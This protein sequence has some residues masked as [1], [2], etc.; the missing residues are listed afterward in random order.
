MPE[1]D[2]SKATL[3]KYLSLINDKAQ[4][5]QLALSIELE[6]EHLRLLVGADT[7]GR[8]IRRAFLDNSIKY[9]LLI[10]LLYHGQFQAQQLAQ[11]LLISEA[12]LGR[13]IS[14]L[15]KLLAEFQFSI[16]NGRL[17]G[18]EHKIRYFYFCLLRKVWASA[19]WKLE[20]DKKERQ[21]EIATLEEL[22]GAKLSQGQ[23][24]DL[25]L[26]SHITQQ[27]LKVNACQF[28]EIEQKM[29]GYTDNIFTNACFVG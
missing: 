26:W 25:V 24:L 27:R 7:K 17:K 18:P 20:L 19:D 28:Q 3:N 12:T 9:Q 29:K 16:H 4:E 15:N 23:R 14:G 1:T 13:H 10:Y 5:N 6:D 11:E 22:C 8:D 2:F 21:S